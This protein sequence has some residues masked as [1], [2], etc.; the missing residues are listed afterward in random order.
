VIVG[1]NGALLRVASERATTDAFAAQ[2]IY[3]RYLHRAI[4]HG[5]TLLALLLLLS[6]L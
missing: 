4:W 1:V 5:A 3:K 2:G 6:A